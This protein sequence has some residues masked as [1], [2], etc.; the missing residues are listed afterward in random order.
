MTAFR[1]TRRAGFTLPELLISVLMMSF[2]MGAAVTFFRSQ[3]RAFNKGAEQIDVLQN[4]RFALNHT[5]RTIRTLG[6]GVAGQQP[7]IVYADS[8]VLAFNTDFIETDS[9]QFRWAVALNPD[10]P[11]TAAVAWDAANA[12]LIPTTTYTYPT[13]TYRLGNGALSPAETFIFWL[14]PD[15]TTARTDDFVLM[16]RINNTPSEV[17]ARNILR[18]PGRPFFEY[19][20]QRRLATG[21]TL[22]TVPAGLRPLIRRPLA[23]ATN[24]T[25]SAN[26]VRPDSVRAVRL[27]LRVTNGQT[28][29]QERTRDVSSLIWVPNNGIPMPSV[30]GRPPFPPQNLRVIPDSAGSGRFIVI[31]DASPDET[32]G[33][34]DVW[35]YVI[36][37][38][39]DSVTVWTDPLMNVKKDATTSD[40]VVVGGYVGGVN[41]R[42][43]VAAQ[44]CTPA[45]STIVNLMRT[46][47]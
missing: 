6:A 4:A 27:N 47:P 44:D 12:G 40:T 20:M 21:D 15:S 7:M 33:E 2:I 41:Y 31:W 22:I 42:I 35:Q 11:P 10:V 18:Y 38:R 46:A 32:S 39:P 23:T 26:F 34:Q 29:A 8:S 19:L 16:Q 9:T 25:D 14:A 1:E 3:T 37:S 45:Q 28:G 5:E 24:A 13:V 17:V 30:C 36:Y 43:G